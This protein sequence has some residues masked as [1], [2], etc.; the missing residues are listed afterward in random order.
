MVLRTFRARE[1]YLARSQPC[2][3]W[4]C[5]SVRE[6]NSRKSRGPFNRI[7]I[8]MILHVFRIRKDDLDRSEKFGCLSV[9][10]HNPRK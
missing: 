4:D 10:H 5:L 8:N 3:K 7:S 1:D 9:R 2:K 6:N